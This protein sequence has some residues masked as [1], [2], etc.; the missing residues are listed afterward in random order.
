MIKRLL[1]VTDGLYRGGAPSPQDVA[2]LKEKL[3]IKKIISLD[4][5][6]GEKIDRTC[7]MLGIDHVKEYIDGSRKSL[8]DLLGHDLNHLLLDGGPTFFHCHEGKDRTGL[9][10]ALFKC[11]YMGVKPVDAIAEAKSLGFGV[12]VN[13]D[14]VHLYER[15]ISNCKPEKDD[16][17]ADI[18]NNE[19]EYIGDNRDSYLDEA[20]RHSWAP[21]LDHTRQNPMDAL[22]VSINDQ[23]P[24]RQNYHQ[25]WEKP[26]EDNEDGI[27]SH[28]DNDSVPQVGIFNNDA[29][30]RGFG[31]TENYSGFFY[32]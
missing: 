19:R 1:K 13:P 5:E 28:E 14:V 2:W 7:K 26:K 24:T 3:G 25:T 31:P 8:Y 6:T 18:V 4:K 29:G 27:N 10:A 23:S 9:V 15:L 11:K 30:Q 12:G 21:F 16:N 32:D 20:T 17:N 22:Y